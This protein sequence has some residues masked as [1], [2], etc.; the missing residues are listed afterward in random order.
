MGI[1]LSIGLIS[2]SILFFFAFFLFGILYYKKRFNLPY[3]IRNTF[4]YEINYQVKF[5]DNIFVNIFLIL[6]LVS[7]IG[8]FIFFDIKNIYGVNLVIV[9]SGILLAILIFFLFFADLKYLRFHLL[10]LVLTAIAAF[11]LPAG[12]AILGFIHYQADH[13]D[14]FSLIIFIISA[15]LALFIFG[16]MMNPKLNFRLEMDKEIDKNGNEKLVRP[17]Y[18]VL[19]FSE[20]IFIFSLFASELLLLLLII[21]L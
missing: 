21:P 19:A 14:I 10:L 5:L 17:K 15:L 16:V 6:S 9:I 11:V 18:F 12:V 8:Y 4:P 3:D 13:S 2:S 1:G 7:S 20:W